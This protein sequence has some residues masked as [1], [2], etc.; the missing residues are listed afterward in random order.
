[1]LKYAI[2]SVSLITVMAGAIIAPAIGSIAVA[3]PDASGFQINLLTSLHAA[4]M[5]PFA[6]VSGF[7]CRYFSKKAILLFSLVLYLVAGV[8]GG[9]APNMFILLCTRALLGISV[10][11]MMPLSTTLVSDNYDGE[12]RTGMMGMVSAATNLGAI[13]AIMIA[14]VLATI[15]WN[16]TFYVY[17]IGAIVMIFVVAYLPRK[18]PVRSK[19]KS[20]KQAAI[21]KAKLATYAIMMFLLFVVFYSIPSNMAL[22]LQENDI[23][24]TILTGIIIAACS[25]GGFLGGMTLARFQRKLKIAYVPVQVMLMGI[26]FAMIVF[27][28][29]MILVGMGVFILGFGYGS[30]VP[31]IFDGVSNLA[32]GAQAMIAWQ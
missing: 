19:T 31:V 5:I 4:F 6:F 20:G 8:G 28:P 14:G 7:L 13:I 29:S 18:A 25:L 30:L 27:T 3:F 24:N 26:G 1:M 10:G 21:P 17:G 32:S 9:F 12:K 15:S 22:Y 11:L 23:T 2:L 16:A